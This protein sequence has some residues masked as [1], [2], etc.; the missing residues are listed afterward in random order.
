MEQKKCKIF[1]SISPLQ[2]LLG[3]TVIFCLL[4]NTGCVNELSPKQYVSW[5]KKSSNG[6]RV[7]QDG[8]AFQYD[9]QYNPSELMALTELGPA[10]GLSKTVVDSLGKEYD[11]LEY[12]TL[13]ITSKQNQD[14]LKQNVQESG[15]YYMRLN[16]LTF[17]MQNDLELIVDSDTIPCA[18]YHCERNYGS[19][20]YMKIS[21]GFPVIELPEQ[22]DRQIKLLSRIEAEPAVISFLIPQD[23]I[24]KIP[25]LKI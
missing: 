10:N 20:P 19:A 8:E 3:A 17:E 15:D 22:G 5:L 11:G 2:Q 14:I 16:Y 6:L 7:Q 12:Y 24:A 23:R 18:L 25:K 1:F 9:L 21:I 4:L 13:K